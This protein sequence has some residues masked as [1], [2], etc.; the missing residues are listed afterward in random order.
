ME[1]QPDTIF[2]VAKN[3]FGKLYDSLEFTFDRSLEKMIFLDD[4]KIARFY[5]VFKGGDRF[6]W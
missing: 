2:N 4:L 6:H 5:P 1:T 3:C